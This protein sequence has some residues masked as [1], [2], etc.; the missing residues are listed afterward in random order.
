MARRKTASI[1]DKRN[2]YDAAEAIAKDEGEA[3]K[4]KVK[5]TPAKRKSKAAKA[6]E[7]RMKLY[8]G[9]FS[10]N[11]KRVALF[12]FDQEKEA[13]ARADE[14]SKGGKSPHFVQK[15]KEAIAAEV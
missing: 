3:P 5:K 6:A 2:E 8:W 11:A 15:V 1:K 10:Q 14:L 7:I 12:E 13:R 9:V 4:K